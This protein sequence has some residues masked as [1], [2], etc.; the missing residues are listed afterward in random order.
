MRLGAILAL[1]LILPASVVNLSSTSHECEYPYVQ[2]FGDQVMVVWS[3]K[4]GGVFNIFSRVYSGGKWG[5]RLRVIGSS[6]HSQY[7]NLALGPGGVIHLIWM[8][9]ISR[10]N[11]DIF[12]ATWSNDSWSKA[13]RIHASTWNS[14]WPRIDLESNG[15]ISV[16]WCSE[17]Y[18]YNNSCYNIVNKRNVNGW[19]GSVATV[20]FTPD[21]ASIHP[22]LAVVGNVS[23]ACWM[24]GE[25]GSWQIAYSR[26]GANGWEPLVVLSGRDGGWWPGIAVDSRGLAHVIYST[27][28]GSPYYTRMLEDGTWS[29]P[30]PVPGAANHQRDFVF[31]EMDAKDVLHASWRQSINGKNNIVYASATAQ[32]DWSKPGYISDGI[33]CRTPVSRP[34]NHGYVHVVWWDEGINNGDVFYAR[35]ESGSGGTSYLNPVAAFTS[36]PIAGAPPL[37]VRFDASASSDE[38]GQITAYNW[39]FG[40]GSGAVGIK[41]THKFLKRGDYRVVLTVTD[42]D[43]LKGTATSIVTVSD[44]PLARFLMNPEIGVA[45]LRVHFD[46]STSNDPDGRI[47]S[48]AWDFGDNTTAHGL[49]QDHTYIEAGDYQVTLEVVDN[50]GISDLAVRTL[51]VLRV[52]PPENV[53][54]AFQENRNLFSVEYLYAVTWQENPLNRHYGIEVKRYHIYRRVRGGDF[55]LIQT[56]SADTFTWLDRFLAEE[57]RGTFEYRVAAVDEQGNESAPQKQNAI[58][59]SK[60]RNFQKTILRDGEN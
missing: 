52:Y 9:G 51:Q 36:D 58:S 28:R 8:E 13:T 46:A 31:I 5:E 6:M 54:Y 17:V 11:R 22:A 48:Y 45:P 60:N 38:D 37:T 50:S 7:P 33:N 41:P 43:G 59:S 55:T 3:E 10:S 44:P 53:T 25:E 12:H 32:G 27:L 24:D 35:V 40:D 57:A 18:P 56:V 39:D 19:S 23:H 49:T 14:S 21:T 20:S 1:A 4:E 16:I 42:N 34:D 30:I 29:L 26:S 2:P 47:L 15:T